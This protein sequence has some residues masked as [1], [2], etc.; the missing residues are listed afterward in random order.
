MNTKITFVHADHF[1]L[2]T[3]DCGF[4]QQKNFIIV[5]DGYTFE[6]WMSDHDVRFNQDSNDADTYFVLD[7]D[8]S[9]E[10]RTGEAYRVLVQEPTSA[11]LEG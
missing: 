10:V 6:D 3:S 1:D 4:D 11:G 8:L 2:G 7:D 9:S 5:G